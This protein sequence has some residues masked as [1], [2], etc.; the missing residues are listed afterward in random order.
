MV[1][2]LDDLERVLLDVAH[3]ET[4]APG[5]PDLDHLRE[6]LETRDAAHR[7]QLAKSTLD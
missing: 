5:A 6:R 3:D 2:L 7:L 1:S 4:P